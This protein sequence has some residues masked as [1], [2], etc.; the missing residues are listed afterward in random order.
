MSE[1]K[2]KFHIPCDCFFPPVPPP[3]IGPT[4]ATG[5]T[6]PTGA[7]GPTGPTGPTGATGP[8]A[9]GC[10]PCNNILNNPGFDIPPIGVDPVPGWN[11]VGSVSEVGF[12]NVHSGRFLPDGSFS[13]LAASIGPGGSINQT[14]DVDEGCCYTLSFAA[15]VRDGA[16]LIASVSF[17]EL[18]QACPPAPATLGPLNIPHIVPVMNQPQ[19]LFQHYT[20][21]VCIPATVTIACISF[22]NTATGGEG[23]T[24]FVD[25]VV[26]QPTGG[27]CTSCSQNF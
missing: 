20:L 22:Q 26:F 18:G 25:N 24:A 19:P 10:C 21:V 9:V 23:A 6:G 27:P 1:F 15:D 14:V 7:T 17:P 8:T 12:P 5:P 13:L 2:K 4:G 11:Q 3:E 16:F